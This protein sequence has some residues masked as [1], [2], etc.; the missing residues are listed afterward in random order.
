MTS[1]TP[2]PPPLPNKN[3]AGCEIT[4]RA[5]QTI[6]DRTAPTHCMLDT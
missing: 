2:P 1:N 5:G 4:Y 6:F 3:R